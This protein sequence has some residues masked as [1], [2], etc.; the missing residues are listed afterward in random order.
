[1]RYPLPAFLENFPGFREAYDALLHVPWSP[2]Q[3]IERELIRG[4]EESRQRRIKAGHEAMPGDL[5]RGIEAIVA[6]MRHAADAAR[7]AA[8]EDSISPAGVLQKGYIVRRVS[9]HKNAPH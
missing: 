3:I 4:I 7:R 9:R 2:H 6:C 1:M 5:R 8:D